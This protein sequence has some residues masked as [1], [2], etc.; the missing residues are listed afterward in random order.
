[1]SN[2][3][4]AEVTDKL[5]DKLSTDDEFRALFQKNPREA[6]RQVGH[7]TPKETAGVAGK[8]PVMCCNTKTLASKEQIRA[9][10]EKLSA[11]LRIHGLFLYFEADQ[12]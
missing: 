1:M 8:D 4:S 11:Q 5:L 10:R 3:F 7:E 6:L 2:H 9:S 12:L